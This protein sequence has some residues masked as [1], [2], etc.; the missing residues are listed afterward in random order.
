[1]IIKKKILVWNL[2]LLVLCMSI[3]TTYTMDNKYKVIGCGLASV[4]CFYFAAVGLVQGFASKVEFNPN[5]PLSPNAMQTANQYFV[6][7][8]L[9]GAAGI[10]LASFGVYLYSK[11]KPGL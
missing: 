10:G 9:C 3:Q 11:S 7:S 8:A 1:M 5:K 6:K 2:L 4:P